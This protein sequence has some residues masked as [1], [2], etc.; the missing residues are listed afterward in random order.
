MRHLYH[1]AMKLWP[2][3]TF[4]FLNAARAFCFEFE[5]PEI[6]LDLLGFDLFDLDEQ[7]AKVSDKWGTMEF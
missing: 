2:T 5:T 6:E 3:K 4:F 7:L 1:F